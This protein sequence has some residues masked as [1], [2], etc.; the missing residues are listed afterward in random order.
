[1]SLYK[2]RSRTMMSVEDKPPSD[3]KDRIAQLSEIYNIAPSLAQFALKKHS[4]EVERVAMMLTDEERFAEIKAQAIAAGVTDDMTESSHDVSAQIV[5]RVPGVNRPTQLLAENTQYFDE[6]FAVLALNRD[7]LTKITWS[8]LRR[9]PP[10]RTLTDQVQLDQPDWSAVLP[11]SVSLLHY[12]LEHVMPRIQAQAAQFIKT[13]GLTRVIEL[14]VSS[15]LF[16]MTRT[17]S[18]QS[19]QCLLQ[20]L[21]LVYNLLLVH[22]ELARE[23]LTSRLM[24]CAYYQPLTCLI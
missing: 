23:Q 16:D 21:H 24:L 15:D 13:H 2:P 11:H 8:L 4:W 19:R 3:A 5:T 12:L 7:D 22:G 20:L 10:P 6:L 9:L 14:L 18:S 17:V 1:M